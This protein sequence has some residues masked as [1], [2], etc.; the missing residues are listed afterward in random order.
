MNFRWFWRTYGEWHPS[1]RELRIEHLRSQSRG[2]AAMLIVL[3]ISSRQFQSHHCPLPIGR[4]CR[5]NL[6]VQM[7]SGMKVC[8]LWLAAPRQNAEP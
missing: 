1:T 5:E 4:R 2:R 8:E 3:L 6:D 7:L